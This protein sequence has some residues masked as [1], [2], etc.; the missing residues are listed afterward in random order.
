MN[1]LH[2]PHKLNMISIPLILLKSAAFI[3]EYP[4]SILTINLC[5]HKLTGILTEKTNYC[6]DFMGKI[7]Q[8]I[9]NCHIKIV[10]NTDKNSS[11]MR[12]TWC[13]IMQQKVQVQCLLT[14]EEEKVRSQRMHRHVQYYHESTGLRQLKLPHTTCFYNL[15]REWSW[16]QKHTSNGEFLN[17][18]LRKHHTLHLCMN[19]LIHVAIIFSS[20]DLL[21]IALYNSTPV[22]HFIFFICLRFCFI[23]LI[24]CNWSKI[25]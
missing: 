16:L 13:Q 25:L 5:F 4:I 11:H 19:M 3:H 9:V 14:F 20:G 10:P 12:A 7:S 17:F 15:V 23:C 21:W 6:I 22:T 8:S 1:P 24:Q 18:H 2:G